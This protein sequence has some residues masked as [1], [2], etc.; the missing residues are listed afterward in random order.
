MVGPWCIRWP[1]LVDDGF[2]LVPQQRADV[3]AQ[4]AGRVEQILVQDGDRVRRGQ[5][6]AT[7]RNAALHAQ[8]ETAAAEH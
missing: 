7:L 3:R 1:V 4:V 2:V 5:P 8:V 6:I